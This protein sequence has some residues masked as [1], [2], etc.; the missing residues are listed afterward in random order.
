M[1]ILTKMYQCTG[2]TCC[3]DR[4]ADKTVDSTCLFWLI[5]LSYRV[6]TPNHEPQDDGNK[7]PL[8]Y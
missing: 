8:L 2:R 7:I 3:L 6:K 4:H 5:G 1:E